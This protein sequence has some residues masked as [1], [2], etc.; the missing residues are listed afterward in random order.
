MKFRSALDKDFLGLVQRWTMAN[1]EVFVVIRYPFAAGARDY[2]LVNSFDLYLKLLNSLVPMSDVH[3]FRQR[4]LLLRGVADD[5]LLALALQEICDEVEWWMIMEL[6]FNNPFVDLSEGLSRDE[7]R[8]EFE[9]YRG[10]IVAI[11]L[12]PPWW[13]KDSEDK[14]SRLI[15]LPNGAVVPSIY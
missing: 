13:E 6:S 1:G 12:E 3:V 9:E 8:A 10:T 4:Q 14:V 7:F 5:A 11:G 15:P 2:L